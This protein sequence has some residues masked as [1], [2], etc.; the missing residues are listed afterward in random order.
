MGMPIRDAM[1]LAMSAYRKEFCTVKFDLCAY[2]HIHQQQ[3]D[4][5]LI[6]INSTNML[7][8]PISLKGN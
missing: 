8:F 5:D 4:P 3:F 2:L 1:R 7:Q 6:D